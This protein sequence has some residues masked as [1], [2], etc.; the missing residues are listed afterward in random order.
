MLVDIGIDF[1]QTNRN[2]NSLLWF[3]TILTGLF[4]VGICLISL[5]VAA[6]RKD[7]VGRLFLMGSFLMFL[8]EARAVISFSGLLWEAQPDSPTA[9]KNWLLIPMEIVITLDLLCF[10]LCFL[11]W[12]RQLA[13]KQAIEQTRVEEQLVHERG[14]RHREALEAELVHQQLEQ[15]KTDVQLRALQAQVNP[16]FLFNSLN[17]LSALI[18]DDPPRASQFVDE[19]SVVYRYLL[20]ANDQQLTTLANELAFIQAYY[21]LLKTRYGTG[22]TLNVEVDTEFH[23]CLLPPLSLQLLV[24]NAVKHNVVLPSRPLLVDIYT[25]AAGHLIVRNNLQRKNTR[26]ISNGVGLTAILHQYHQL[27]QPPPEITE[28]EGQFSIR[29]PLIIPATD[30]GVPV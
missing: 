28:A 15:E 27:K 12:Q 9:I 5:W 2:T 16:H 17:S 18:E 21:H 20:K 22:L 24:E 30:N 26:T 7:I 1:S 3:A 4:F 23:P 10:S 14:Q 11:F 8:D 13:V 25:D 6:Q 19:L 29:L